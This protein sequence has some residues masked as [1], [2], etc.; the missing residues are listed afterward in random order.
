MRLR[1][2]FIMV[3]AG[4]FAYAALNDRNWWD[5]VERTYFQGVALLCVWIAP[6]RRIASQAAEG[7][8]NHG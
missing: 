6:K 4:N 5:A 1:F 2:I 7:E 8:R 3:A